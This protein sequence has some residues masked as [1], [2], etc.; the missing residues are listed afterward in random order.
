MLTDA[1]FLIGAGGHGKVVLE[2]LLQNEVPIDR[3]AIS[4]NDIALRDKKLLGASISTPAMPANAAAGAF[5]VAIGNGTIRQRLHGELIA[6]GSRPL[7]TVHPGALVS[8]FASI[9]AG[10]FI[11]AR[12]IVGPDAAIGE[13]VIINHGAVVDHDCQVGAFS[14]I[15][16]NATLA[17]AVRVGA[18]VLVGAGANVLPNLKIGDD[19]VIGAG[20]VVLRDIAAGE[21]YVGVPAAP[22]SRSKSD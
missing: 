2:A 4:D 3:I 9:G 16:P 18:R 7:T 11:A 8:R 1:I 6:A 17:G 14:H 12:A 20:A 21:M 5:H 19:A 13:G 10:S 22:I 15:A